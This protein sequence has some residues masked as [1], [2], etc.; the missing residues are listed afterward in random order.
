MALPRPS[1]AGN[2]PAYLDNLFSNNA[3]PPL[4]TPT[5]P[6]L[7]SASSSISSASAFD[8][9]PLQTKPRPLSP[10]FEEEQSDDRMSVRSLRLLSPKL[11]VRNILNRRTYPQVK[12]TVEYTS[13]TSTSSHS[14][15]HS[16]TSSRRPSLPKLQTA[17][18]SPPRRNN[19]ITSKPLPA[20]PLP[21]AEEL[22]C[23]RCYYFTARHCKG[24]VIGGSHGDACDG[25][26]VSARN[27][28]QHS[29][30]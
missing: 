4:P 1:M 11:R 22:T 21:M 24:Y 7:R 12:E 14:H 19:P 20:A 29:A 25:C 6:S 13:T 17:F 2:R 26:A 15:N 27:I 10:A 16:T 8:L 28:T 5:T 30:Y 18:S 9:R 23:K 3:T